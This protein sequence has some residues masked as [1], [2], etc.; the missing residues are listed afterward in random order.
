MGTKHN[1]TKVNILFV[2][3]ETLYISKKVSTDYP[4]S[5]LAYMAHKFKKI[6]I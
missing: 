1:A 3:A 4:I 2:D 5:A 6:Q